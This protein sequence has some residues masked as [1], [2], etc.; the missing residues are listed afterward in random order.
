MIFSK[1]NSYC[2]CGNKSAFPWGGGSSCYFSI[3][4]QGFVGGGTGWGRGGGA[5]DKVENFGFQDVNIQL[6]IEWKNDNKTFQECN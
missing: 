6:F 4:V 1:I 3:C 2:Y 5:F